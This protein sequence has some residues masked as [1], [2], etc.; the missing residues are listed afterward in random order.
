MKRTSALILSAILALVPLGVTLAAEPATA[1]SSAP[2]PKEVT[3]VFRNQ[4]SDVQ[5]ILAPDNTSYPVDDHPIPMD[6]HRE[7]NTKNVLNI[8]T[9]RITND[10]SGQ[11]P[12]SV[13]IKWPG[14]VFTV[15]TNQY[16][17]P[18][19][20]AFE[21]WLDFEAQKVIIDS[22]APNGEICRFIEEYIGSNPWM[23]VTL[24]TTGET[25]HLYIYDQGEMIVDEQFN[26]KDLLEEQAGV[27]VPSSIA[28]LGSFE[29]KKINRLGLFGAEFSLNTTH[30]LTGD[31]L[32]LTFEL[33]D[34]YYTNEELSLFELYLSKL[35][36]ST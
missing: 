7:K 31:P 3:V 19:I 34:I 14:Y 5:A 28:E 4:A 9:S 13:S 12:E 1:P 25:V 24:P 15:S 36:W 17:L 11:M 27:Q 22:K 6:D 26:L 21:I 10:K 35:D 30:L 18:T 16:L 33:A 29:A 20:Y 32:T 2:A 8:V 23:Q